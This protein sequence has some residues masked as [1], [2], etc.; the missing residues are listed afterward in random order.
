MKYAD[1]TTRNSL[2]TPQEPEVPK[3]GLGL[4]V[5]LVIVLVVIGVVIGLLFLKGNLSKILNPVSIVANMSSVNLKENDGR[6]NVLILGSDKRSKSDEGSNLTDTILIASIGK[7][8]KDVVLIS[9]PR[10]LWV[11]WLDAEGQDHHSKIN[12][13]Y[14]IQN[15]IDPDSNKGSTQLMAT[16]EDVLGIKIHYYTMVNF[17]LFREIIDTLGG[18]DVNVETTFTDHFYPIEGKEDAPVESDRYETVT[19]TAGNQT[20]TGDTALKYV[21]SRHGD[22]GEGTDFARSKRQQK[23]I[24]AIKSKA[25]SAQTLLNLNKI[26]DLYDIYSKNIDTNLDLQTLQSFFVL[27]Q[28]IDFNKVVSIVLDDRSEATTGGGLLYAPE[29]T[30][31]YGNQY[32]LIPKA[33]DYSQIHAYVQKYLFGDK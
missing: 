23:V 19:F 2:L 15:A 16:L 12:A 5:I 29:D 22:N 25:L 30:T 32:V 13:I 18:V 33:G 24:E 10:D 31:L 14:P 17:D 1:I 20:M 26:K 28:Q 27:S 6:T 9:V 7:V 8:D 21:R 11:K 3:K 4:G